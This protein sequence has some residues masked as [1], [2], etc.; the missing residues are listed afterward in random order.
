MVKQ[1]E[2]VERLKARHAAWQR[3]TGAT[4][5]STYSWAADE[6]LRLRALLHTIAAQ[7][8]P[9]WGQ[10]LAR[11]EIGVSPPPEQ[12]PTNDPSVI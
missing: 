9:K 3:E 4:D 1:V 10:W 11:E 6:I 2:I 8:D 12:S 7:T 5:E